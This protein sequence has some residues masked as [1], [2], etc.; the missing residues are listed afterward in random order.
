MHESL[1]QF[2]IVEGLQ[3]DEQT[4]MVQVMARATDHNGSQKSRKSTIL[5]DFH[6]TNGVISAALA[7]EDCAL[8]RYPGQDSPNTFN[9]GH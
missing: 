8:R 3:L 7:R 2:A 4:V 6:E 5:G 9:H 1:P